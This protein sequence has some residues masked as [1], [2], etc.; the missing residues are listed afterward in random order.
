MNRYYTETVKLSSYHQKVYG[1]KVDYRVREHG[2]DR[3]L[4]QAPT[5]DAA[6]AAAERKLAQID[7]EPAA[8]PARPQPKAQPTMERQATRV[9]G[10]L[11]APAPKATGRCHYCGLPLGRHGECEECV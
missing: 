3:V 9:A 1:R 8:A 10:F 4:A 5:E 6:I 7:A 2:T 11:D